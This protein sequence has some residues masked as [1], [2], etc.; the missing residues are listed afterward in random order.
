[1]TSR[2]PRIANGIKGP[3]GP[4]GPAGAA[5]SWATTQTIKA[6]NGTTYIAISSDLG[7]L[8]TL[9]ST[10]N[11]LNVTINTS[12]GLTA[13]Q[14]IDFVQLGTGQVVFVNSGVTLNFTPG[15]KLRTRY[16][17][18]T[19]ICLSSNNYLLVGDLSA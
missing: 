4:T 10:A 14:R 3:T 9:N 18:A 6:E 5:G 12:L 15:L 1:M 11:P 13:G 19:L 8:V 2:D 16:S 7:K 17:S